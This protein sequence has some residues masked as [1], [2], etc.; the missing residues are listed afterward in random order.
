MALLPASLRAHWLLKRR[1]ITNYYQ[2]LRVFASLDP[3]LLPSGRFLSVNQDKSNSAWLGPVIDPGMIGPL[4]D[5]GITSLHMDLRVVQQHVD[6]A[7][8][9]NGIVNASRAMSVGMTHKSLR[10]RINAH[11]EQHLVMINR[12]GVFRRRWKIDNAEN[13]SVGRRRN[14]NLSL[15]SVG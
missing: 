6:F 3:A 5:K 11:S 13:G 8:Q 10:R 4:L 2:Q 15:A 14:A 12:L 7:V 1:R 9:H